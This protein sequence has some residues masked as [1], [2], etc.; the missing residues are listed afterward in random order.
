[1]SNVKLFLAFALALLGSTQSAE[2]VPIED[3]VKEQLQAESIYG[4]TS[5]IVVDGNTKTPVAVRYVKKG[6][7]VPS[8]A[9]IT[10]P[11][12]EHVVDL[13]SPEIGGDLPSCVAPIKPPIVFKSRKGIYVVY[14]YIVEDPRKV[15]T[16]TLH[17]FKLLPSGVIACK[18]EEDLVGLVKGASKKIGVKQN[19]ERAIERLGCQ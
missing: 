5:P 7:L 4:I 16:N 10:G 19:F 11:S 8:C 2:A 3:V 14:E 12:I 18:N 9:L 6:D 13:V 15:L 17:L 1:M